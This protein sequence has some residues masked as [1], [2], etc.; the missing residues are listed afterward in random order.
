MTIALTCP[1]CGAPLPAIVPGTTLVP[2]AYCGAT[3]ALSGVHAAKSGP[4]TS[5]APHADPSLSQ[6]VM[7]TFRLALERGA[8]PFDALR[9]AARERLGPI[10]QT[11]AFALVVHALAADFDAENKTDVVHDATAMGR[12]IDVYL[13]AMAQLRVEPEYTVNMPFFQANTDGPVHFQRTLTAAVI[14]DLATRDPVGKKKKGW[15]G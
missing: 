15:F 11:D 2:C 3:A 4:A 7:E 6:R 5:R 1:W 14:A 8:T 10:G 9:A 12:L 13:L